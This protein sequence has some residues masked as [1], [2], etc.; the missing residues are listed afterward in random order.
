MNRRTLTDQ[1]R[2]WQRNLKSI[3][4]RKKSEL[5]LTQEKLA[6]KIGWRTQGAVTSYLNGRIPLNTDAKMKFAEAL[7]VSVSEIDSGIILEALTAK[8]FLEL[9]RSALMKLPLPELL[10]LSGGVDQIIEQAKKEA[11]QK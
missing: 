4:L 9:N 11:A 8:D 1:E 6:A 10:R 3:W 2:E 5:G 7:G